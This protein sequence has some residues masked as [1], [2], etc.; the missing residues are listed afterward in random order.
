MLASLVEAVKVN[1]DYANISKAIP[2][3]KCYCRSI[4]LSSQVVEG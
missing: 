1:S 2:G 3:L 4:S